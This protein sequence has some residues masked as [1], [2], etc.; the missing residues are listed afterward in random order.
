MNTSLLREPALIGPMPMPERPF[1]WLG[2]LI[3][4]L[5][6][7]RLL[8]LTCVAA[9]LTL[10]VLYLAW[11]APRFTASATL[12]V[13]MPQPALFQQH[14][15]VSDAQ[16]QSALI[17]SEVEVLR[18]AGLARQAVAALRL[19]DDPD[20]TAASSFSRLAS[21]LRSRLGARLGARLGR[22][23]PVP[24][25]PTQERLVQQFMGMVAA[26]RIGLTYIIEIDAT[27]KTP[28]LAAALA[29]G[30]AQTYLD[31]RLAVRDA[32][33]RKAADWVQSRLAQLHD[34]ALRAD[35]QVQLFKSGSGI[36][37]TGHGLLDEQQ[38]TEL[39]SQ[40]VA[41]RGRTIEASARLDRIRAMAKSGSDPGMAVSDVLKSQVINGLRERYLTDAAQAASWSGQFG[42]NN[43]ALVSL[44]HEMV[45]LQASIGREIRRIE[46]TASGDLGADR[47]G[48][49]AIQAQLDALVRQSERSGSARA[50]LRSLQSSA[51][52]Y[53]A[54]Y[55]AFLQ[56]AVQT[57]QDESFPIVDAR[58]VTSARPPLN[59]S[60]PQGKLILAGAVFL[61]LGI[62]FVIGLARE[63]L[64]HRLRNQ[65]DL[66]ADT[67]LNCLATLPSVTK[68]HAT[69]ERYALDHP[70]TPFGLGI[71][72]LQLRLQQQGET[73]R[74]RLLGLI[75]PSA[76]AGVSMV[77]ANLAT[78]LTASGHAASLLV[79]SGGAGSAQIRGQI[80]R[81]RRDNAF[82]II[83]FP[84]LDRP[85][86]AHTLFA[87]VGSFALLVEAGRLD[88]AAL[89]ESLRSAGL[90]RR[91][92]IG[93]VLN[94]A[95]TRA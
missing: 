69:L 43:R 68:S 60:R 78:S 89:L 13:D 80:E 47:A 3:G 73:G 79:L 71:R 53:R 64:D 62:G 25:M 72:R 20:F 52:T 86:E 38:L 81:L 37:D 65:A 8:L 17:E 5:R 85:V 44:Q 27:A 63:A 40:L 66:Q 18:S 57:V 22:P 9:T 19:A 61:G 82:V 67:G 59:K 83:D 91:N 7:Y 4:F 58:V 23:A 24:G 93:V 87:E 54:L 94:R 33:A 55:A 26:H 6:R 50:A 11:A 88:G 49:A 84:P 29:N 15:S 56:R 14:A 39:S 48:E 51:D 90:D 46:Q 95:R 16:I 42:H 12:V 30:L 34:E 70:E 35:Q 92:V 31:E 10:A 77:A 75:A 28:E 36:V 74:A 2:D 45:A 21:L 41:A 32:S 1:A 76:G